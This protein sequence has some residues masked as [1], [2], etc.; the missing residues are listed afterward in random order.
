MQYAVIRSGGKQYKVNVGD[1]LTID[2]LS[3]GDKKLVVFD[4]VLLVVDE[5]KVTLGKPNIKGARVEASLI[6]NKKGEKIRVSKFKAKVRFRKTIGFR[7]QLSVVKIE[8]IAFGAEKTEKKT[9]KTAKTAT[10]AKK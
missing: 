7:P 5:D 4:E 6:E 8:K 1:T 10:K 9:A 2:K 3:S